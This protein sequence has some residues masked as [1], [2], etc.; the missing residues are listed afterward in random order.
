MTFRSPV[1]RGLF[2]C[3]VSFIAS[4]T[5]SLVASLPAAAA[6]N[7]G[8]KPPIVLGVTGELSGLAVG[9]EGLQGATAY[10]DS[11]NKRGGLFG[12]LI[13][14]K[15]YDDGRDI[16]RVVQNTQKLIAEDHVFALFGYRSTPSL[17]AAIP[18][19]S[20]EGVPMIAPYSGAQS[21][22]SP[23]NPM[24]FHLR[25]SYQQEATKLIDHLATEGVRKIAVFYQDDPFGKDALSGMEQAL[26]KAGLTAIAQANYDRK[27]LNIEAAVKAIAAAAPDAVVMA[28]TP[29]ACADFIKQ[30][31]AAGRR[32]QFLL[33]SNVNSNEFVKSLGDLGRGV[34][35]SQVVPYPWSNTI[36]LAREYQQ[37]LKDGGSKV[38][39]SYASF[40]GF[41]A[42]KLVVN[43]LRS[44]GS[45]PTRAGLIAALE[46]MDDVDLGGM[47]VHFSNKSHNGSSFVDLT[48]ISLSGTYIH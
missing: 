18:I 34:V 36:P 48:L 15:A 6:D 46:K 27:T 28:C 9:V 11:V 32:P 10:F 39:V 30:M 8:S 44:A 45:D 31:N 1:L 4:L 24:V 41:I 13:E 42:A 21:V 7:S 25:A 19:L 40:E 26:K 43:A 23:H 2:H 3:L 37:A 14:L 17:E 29:S 16:K 12:R 20:K 5:V 38:P 35:M 33:L 47:R 22:R